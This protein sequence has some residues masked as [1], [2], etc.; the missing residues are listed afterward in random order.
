[1]NI[2]EKTIKIKVLS[3]LRKYGITEKSKILVGYSGGPDSSA[4]LWILN[5]I[6]KLLGFSLHAIYIDHGIRSEKEMS[7]EYSQIKKI[8]AEFNLPLHTRHIVQ[9]EIASE[10]VVSG[11][12][13]EDLAREYR[14]RLIEEIKKEIGASHVAMGHNL[15]DQFETLIMRFFQG[16]GIHGFM[17]IPEKREYFIRP[18]IM[19]E[20]REIMEYITS[21]NIPYVVDRTNLDTVYLR[22]KVRLKLIPVIAEIFPGYRKSLSTFSEKMDSIRSVL[23]SNNPPLDVELTNEGDTWFYSEDFF[24]KPDYQQVETL[25]K[26]WNMWEKR[27]FNRLPYRFISA[28]L[29]YKPVG[30]SNIL[31]QGYSCQLLHQKEKIIW[32]R[33]VV[34]SSKKS[35]LRVVVEGNLEIFPGFTLCVEEMNKFPEDTV[36][37]NRENL[38]DPVIIRSKMSGDSIHLAEG[39]KP[40]KKLFSDWGVLPEDRWKVPVVEDRSGIIAVLGKPFGFNNRIAVTYKNSSSDNGKL[41]ISARYM[42]K[43]K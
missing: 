1:M 32:K 12:S 16:S 34:V 9:G 36:W 22:N 6:Q 10:S 7:G 31:I 19:L 35:Y 33:V 5:D 39:F 11:R 18:L 23:T 14:Y 37:F 29:D 25:Y 17:G 40:I 21:N 27:P 13:I 4:L 15:D 3:F 38:K 24:A 30:G 42:E 28:A 41:V 26:S 8:V 2:T 20:K 43:H